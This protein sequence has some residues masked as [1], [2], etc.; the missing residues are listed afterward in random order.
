MDVDKHWTSEEVGLILR[1][2]GPNAQARLW[3]ANQLV[4]RL[5]ETLRCLQA[6]ELH[7][8][9]AVRLAEAVLGLTD[10]QTADVQAQLLAKVAARANV[11]ITSFCRS[12]KRAVLR[13]APKTADEAHADALTEQRVEVRPLEHGM[14]LLLAWLPAPDAL[15]VKAAIDAYAKTPTITERITAGWVAG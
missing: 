11:S 10:E 14:A 7:P 1:I 9:Q 13:A 4:T 3:E 5:P 2:S 15:R 6:G 8:L 12:L